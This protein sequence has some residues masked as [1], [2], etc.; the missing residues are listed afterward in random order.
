M[1][2]PLVHYKVEILVQNPGDIAKLGSTLWSIAVGRS[3]HDAASHGQKQPKPQL[4][5]QHVSSIIFLVV[6]L[7]DSSILLA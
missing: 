2:H 5:P 1:L 6:P 7:S 3:R 4:T